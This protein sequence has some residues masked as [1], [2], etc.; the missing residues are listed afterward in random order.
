MPTGLGAALQDCL[1]LYAR[2]RGISQ[3]PDASV[4]EPIHFAFVGDSTDKGQLQHKLGR[5]SV[6]ACY[7]QVSLAREYRNILDLTG[8]PR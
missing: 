2:T 6:D 8:A 3:G 4:G 5:R 7:D 1:V